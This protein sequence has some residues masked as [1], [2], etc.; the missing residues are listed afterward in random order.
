MPKKLTINDLNKV[1]EKL[2]IHW[3]WN[4]LVL[5]Q[6]KLVG[7]TCRAYFYLTC[8]LC[9]KQFWVEW[10]A[11]KL[12]R[13]KCCSNCTSLVSLEEMMTIVKKYNILWQ[14]TTIFKIDEKTNRRKYWMKCIC[15]KQQWIRWNHFQQGTATGCRSC[16]VRRANNG[17]DKS[18]YS[19]CD[20]KKF[21]YRMN[22]SIREQNNVTKSWN[23]YEEFKSWADSTNYIEGARL[24]RISSK[25]NFDN[26]NCY[27]DTDKIKVTTPNLVNIKGW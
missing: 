2:N 27:W 18:N 19:R 23:N 10:G 16:T 24:V 9:D 14:P 1:K 22:R 5:P 13:S 12:G 15:G 26:D 11:V 8:T 20:L 21:W 4:S 7:S 25:G 6:K 17:L 3:S